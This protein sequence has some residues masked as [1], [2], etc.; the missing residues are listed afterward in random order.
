ML[1]EFRSVRSCALL[2]PGAPVQTQGFWGG[3]CWCCL[4]PAWLG[5]VVW[6]LMPPPPASA[7]L[8]GWGCF[9]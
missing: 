8:R 7:P 4:G 3:A 9:P 2:D 1:M 6:V 5:L